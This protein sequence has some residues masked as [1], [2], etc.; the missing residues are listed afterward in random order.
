MK[1][2]CIIGIVGIIILIEFI[3]EPD[4]LISGA[5]QG[6]VVCGNIVIPSL[7]P[8]TAITI[9]I[10]RS[11]IFKYIEK[12]ITPVTR[13]LFG[14]NGECFCVFIMSFLGGFPVGAKLINELIKNNSINK[15]TASRMICY[16]VNSGPA[17]MV[18]GIGQTILNNLTLGWIIYL[19]NIISSLLMC[20]AFSYVEKKE[21]TPQNNKQNLNNNSSDTFVNSVLDAFSSVIGICGFVI[22][23]SS[24]ISIFSSL[25]KASEIIKILLSLLE[26]S[27]GI[28]MFSKSYYFLPFLSGFAGLCVHMQILS[29]SKDYKINY[30]LFLLSRIISGLLSSG[31]TIMIIKLLNLTLPVISINYSLLNNLSSNSVILF[32]ALLSMSITLLLSLKQN[33]MEK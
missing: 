1:K 33:Y 12:F 10:F 7:F 22:L 32:I 8:F 11:G 30:W 27:N 28:I 26:V 9:F 23:F 16:C 13:R 19:S 21:K 31:I 4:L 25:S 17:F 14:I 15:K 6:I 18:F 29:V 2:I 24:I 20:F 5:K 3:C